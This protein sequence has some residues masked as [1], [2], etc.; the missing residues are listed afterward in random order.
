MRPPVTKSETIITTSV[1]RA[2]NDPGT[3]LFGSPVRY[4]VAAVI[5]GI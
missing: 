5:K 2:T 3:L 1:T 4:P